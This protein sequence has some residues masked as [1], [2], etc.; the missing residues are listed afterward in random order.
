VFS[1]KAGILGHVHVEPELRQY[2]LEKMRL[3]LGTM[4][5]AVLAEQ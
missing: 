1:E 3:Q 2:L 5:Y 4:V